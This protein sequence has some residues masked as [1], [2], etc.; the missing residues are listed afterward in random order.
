MEDIVDIVDEIVSMMNVDLTVIDVNGAVITVCSIKWARK[1]KLI[2]G[3]DEE[4]YLIVSVNNDLSQITLGK[5][6]TSPGKT[7]KI[8][9]PLY[10]HGTPR[11]TNSEWSAFSSNEMNKVPWIWLVEPVNERIE[12]DNSSIER[13]SELEILFIDSRDGVN[14]T[15]DQIHAERSGLLYNMAT[16]FI[17]TIKRT[18]KFARLSPFNIMN[19]AKLGRE[20]Q[21]GFER[22]IIDSDL[23][24]LRLRVTLPIYKT[25]NCTC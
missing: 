25:S 4:P 11:V 9:L 8:E 10:F 22:N 21:S 13:R 1:G 14:W 12:D 6:F 23:T 17:N 18:P 24:A 19:L 15:N 7:V 20:N 16:E 2:I 3:S 5:A